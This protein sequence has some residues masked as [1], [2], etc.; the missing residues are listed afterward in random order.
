MVYEIGEYVVYNGCEICKICGREMKS[1][2]DVEKEYCVLEPMAA[3][4]S[5]YFIPSDLAEMKM[6]KL[7][8]KDEVIALIDEMPEVSGDWSANKNER[9]NQYVKVLHSNDYR[10]LISVIKTIHAEQEKRRLGGKRL[11]SADERAMKAAEQLLHQEFSVVLGIHESEV[12]E[13]IKNRIESK[14]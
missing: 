4:K 1:F 13:Y 14:A 10:M 2:D 12:E 3:Q 5:A 7:L 11:P 6:R 9:R 8:T